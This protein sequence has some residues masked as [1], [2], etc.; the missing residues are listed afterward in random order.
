M[1][2]TTTAGSS[3]KRRRANVEPDINVT[4]LVDVVLV[5]LII[6]MVIAPEMEHGQRV[7]LPAITTPDEGPKPKIPPVMVTISAQGSLF[8]EKEPIGDVASLVERLKAAHAEE[9]DRKIV[10]KGDASLPY[11]KLRALLLD[12]QNGGLPGVAISV[13][14]KGGK[15]PKTA[16]EE[17][18]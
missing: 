14:Q 18:G 9:P 8:L 13:T 2:S 1:A 10:L 3:R 11:S 4:P 7:E 6:F 16:A 15:G 12:M 5:L 17:G